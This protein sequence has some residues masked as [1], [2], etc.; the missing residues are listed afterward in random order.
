EK[1]NINKPKIY[2]IFNE[3]KNRNQF[4]HDI[5]VSIQDAISSLKIIK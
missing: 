4:Q 2:S 3:L 5:P 1:L